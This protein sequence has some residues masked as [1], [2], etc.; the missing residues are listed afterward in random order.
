MGNHNT[1]TF[2][3]PNAYQTK[4]TTIMIKFLSFLLMTLILSFTPSPNQDNKIT[5][6]LTVAQTNTVLRGLS[7][8]PLEESQE[9]YMTVMVQ[10][11]QQMADT[12]KPKK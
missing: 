2:E 10:A 12:T 8:L 5:L 3:K 7:K 6:K 1:N 11:Q 9:T 4:K